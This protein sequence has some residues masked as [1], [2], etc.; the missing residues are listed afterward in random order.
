M[1]WIYL[2]L[3]AGTLFVVRMVPALLRLRAANSLA[4]EGRLL[5]DQARCLEP[6]PIARLPEGSVT[7]AIGKARPLDGWLVAPVSKTPCVYYR[8]VVSVLEYSVER[9]GRVWQSIHE[10][11]E[12]K[13]FILRDHTGECAVDPS[14]ATTVLA[15]KRAHRFDR[16]KT[17]DAAQDLLERAG[18]AHDA[19]RRTLL[20]EETLLPI[21]ATV[22]VAGIPK[23]VTLHGG[24]EHDYRSG[25][26]SMYSFCGTEAELLISDDRRL[27]RSKAKRRASADRPTWGLPAIERSSRA[28]PTMSPDEFEVG[29]RAGRRRR[30]LLGVGLIVIIASIAV[31]GIFASS[32]PGPLTREHRAE[33]EKQLAWSQHELQYPSD[34]GDECWRTALAQRHDYRHASEAC[35][36]SAGFENALKTPVSAWRPQP[37]LSGSMPAPFPVIAIDAGGDLPAQSPRSADA[38]TRAAMIAS[39]LDHATDDHFSALLDGARL[40]A[41]AMD[42]LV[43]V[44]APTASARAWA[45]DHSAKQIVCAGQ[46]AITGVPTP[47]DL[48][49]STISSLHAARQ[50]HR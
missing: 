35:A 13:P 23:L 50:R 29:M 45:Y 36:S 7:R 24:G 44:D 48:L 14:L 10:H 12:S 16:G 37:W 41:A 4:R 3:F 43:E 31:F 32:R 39:A 9:R 49:Y 28:I 47:S 30:L 15:T 33:I 22:A 18:I 19:R 8:A 11:A 25:P 5:T 17:S 46:F 1:E 42:L 34:C 26:P 6:C 21:G 2:T 38:H 27:L 20:V 40:D